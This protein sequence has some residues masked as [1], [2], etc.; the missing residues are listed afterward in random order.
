M[1]TRESSV[2]QQQFE[3]R[4]CGIGVPANLVLEAALDIY[5][6]KLARSAQPCSMVPGSTSSNTALS[7]RCTALS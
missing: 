3:G 1:A 5:Q 4:S 2:Q 7:R 6:Y